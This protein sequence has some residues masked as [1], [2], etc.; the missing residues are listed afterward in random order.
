[1]VFKNMDFQAKNSDIPHGATDRLLDAAE[2]LFCE[3][4]FDGTSVRDLTNEAGC[5]VAAVNYHF[6]NKENLYKQ[7]FQRHLER[8]FDFHKQN[9]KKVMSA[10]NP[11]VEKLV[12]A[13]VRPTLEPSAGKESQIPM[14]KLTIRESLNPQFKTEVVAL[15]TIREFVVEIQ[16][17]LIVLFPQLSQ[18][19]AMLCVFSLEGMVIHPLLFGEFYQ[20]IISG[21]TSEQLIRHIVRFASDGIRQAVNSK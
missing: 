17:A 10:E 11:T 2:K 5:N 6:G 19:K 7:M 21:L 14:L 15:E 1:M 8:V 13:L 18:E 16:K 12:E 3:R 4:G 20:D 9:I